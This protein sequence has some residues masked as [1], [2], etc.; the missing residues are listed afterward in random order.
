AYEI[1]MEK[2]GDKPSDLAE[3]V[4]KDRTT[5]TNLTRLLKLPEDIQKLI[6]N[7]M[8]TAGQARPLLAIADRRTS[9]KLADRICRENWS[10]RRVEDE[11]AKLQGEPGARSPVAKAAARDPNL[12]SVEAKLRT[13][14]GAKVSL[15][16]KKNGAGKLTV[17]YG[18]LDD[19]D[20][21]LHGMGIKA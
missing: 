9:T 21:I 4:G 7:K 8:M 3:K 20:R 5:I 19:L 10:A 2:T 11:V 12:K 17:F 16:H 18:N 1:W 6:E 15:N 14:L 13:K